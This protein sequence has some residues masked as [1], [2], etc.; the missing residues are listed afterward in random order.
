VCECLAAVDHATAVDDA[1]VLWLRD[2]LGPQLSR[3]TAQQ[4]H[5]TSLHTFAQCYVLPH[6]H[7]KSLAQTFKL[8]FHLPFPSLACFPFPFPSPCPFPCFLLYIDSALVK[9]NSSL[10]TDIPQCITKTSIY[11]WESAD[12]TDWLIPNQDRRSLL[13]LFRHIHLGEGV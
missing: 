8:V 1:F 13:S 3:T 7:L 10:N 5:S 12:V 11:R 4:P 9:Y 2:N 6:F